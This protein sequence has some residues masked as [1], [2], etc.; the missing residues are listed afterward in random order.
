MGQAEK[1]S[2]EEFDAKKLLVISAVG[3]RQYYRKLGYLLDGPY[4]AKLLV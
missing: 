2:K 4:M 3:T 1:I